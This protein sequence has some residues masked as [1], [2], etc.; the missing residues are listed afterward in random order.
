MSLWC[1][2]GIIGYRHDHMVKQQEGTRRGI[3]GR[4]GG[5]GEIMIGASPVEVNRKGSSQ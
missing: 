2:R 1:G 4:E 3:K 5:S